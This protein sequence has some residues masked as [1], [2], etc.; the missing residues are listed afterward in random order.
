VYARSLLVAKTASAWGAG[1]WVTALLPVVGE[2][3][4]GYNRASPSTRK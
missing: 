2:L 4:I 3:A 1:L